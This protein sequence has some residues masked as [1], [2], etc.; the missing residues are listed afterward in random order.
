[1]LSVYIPLLLCISPYSSHQDA[2][3][4]AETAILRGYDVQLGF[5]AGCAV[6][7]FVADTDYIDIHGI[8]VG[9]NDHY[10]MTYDRATD[11]L[12]AWETLLHKHTR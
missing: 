1:M 7:V 6:S 3:T 12:I 8:V 5:S 2:H 4:I 10:P 11:L 9:Y